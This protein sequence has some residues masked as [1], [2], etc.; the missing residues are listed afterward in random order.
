MISVLV[1]NFF[2]Y[3][4]NIDIFNNLRGKLNVYKTCNMT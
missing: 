1:F 3:P 4:S 2:K